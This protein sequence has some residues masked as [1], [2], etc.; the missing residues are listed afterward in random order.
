[1]DCGALPHEIEHALSGKHTYAEFRIFGDLTL[2][3]CDFHQVDFGSYD[4]IYFG[5]PKNTKLGF[6]IMQFVRSIDDIRITK[7]IFQNAARDQWGKIRLRE[8]NSCCATMLASAR[9]VR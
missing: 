6:Q 4:P 1:M 9:I 2:V 8:I 5:L 3:L 7:S